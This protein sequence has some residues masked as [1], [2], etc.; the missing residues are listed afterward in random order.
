ME[1]NPKLRTL[2]E[3]LLKDNYELPGYDVFEKD[4]KDPS[5]SKAFYD[6]LLKDNYELP[7]YD[8]FV[9]DLGL[10]KKDA[11]DYG[12][13]SKD[14]FSE[15][16]GTISSPEV[17]RKPKEEETAEPES[18]TPKEFK[19]PDL[20]LQSPEMK[21]YEEPSLTQIIGQTLSNDRI[22]L[23]AEE[24][25][26]EAKARISEIE[27]QLAAL[28][29]DNLEMMP[30]INFSGGLI[31]PTRPVSDEKARLLK[32]K[33]DLRMATE[34]PDKLTYILGKGYNQSLFGIADA[35]MNEKRRASEE[36]LSRYDAGT[37]TDA[38]ATA[39][40]FLIDAPF[41]GMAGKIGGSIGKAAAKPIVDRAVK[42]GVEKLILAGMEE[43]IAKKIALKATTRLSQSIIGMSSSGTALGSY[44]AVNSALSDWSAPDAT[45]D[46]IKWKNAFKRGAKDYVLGLGV[47]GL[48]LG[49][50][51]IAEKARAIK[52]VA[53]RVGTQVGIATGGLT[54]ES[55][56]FTYGGALLDG[57]APNDVTGKEFLETVALLSILK[58][59]HIAQKPGESLKNMYRSAKYDPKKPG[60]GEFQVDLDPIEI[61]SL[62]MSEND[63]NNIMTTLAKDD[64]KLAEVMKDENVPALVKQKVLWGSRGV[65]INGTNLYVDKV[66]PKGETIDLV[67]KEGV[68]VDRRKFSSKEEADQKTL[69]IGLQLE[70]NKMQ[71]R[72]AMPDVDRVKVISDLKNKGTDI[73]KLLTALDKPV[74]ERT[75]EESKMVGDYYSLIPKEDAKAQEKEKKEDAFTVESLNERA[76][77]FGLTDRNMGEDII[78][79][80]LNAK[81]VGL[82]KEV[83]AIPK[84][85]WDQLRMDAFQMY[86]KQPR[87]DASKESGKKEKGAEK[88][89][90]E[91]KQ[92]ESKEDISSESELTLGNRTETSKSEKKILKIESDKV[93]TVP[94]MKGADEVGKATIEDSDAGWRIKWI[95][96]EGTRINK[97]ARGA[98]REAMTMLNKE[99]M[100]EGKVLISDV[101]GKNSTDMQ[102]AWE[103]LVDAGEAV[104]L[105]DKSWAFKKPEKE[106]ITVV[107]KNRELS[108]NE[109]ID[110]V[111]KYNALTPTQK[112]KN[113]LQANTIR[114]NAKRLGYELKESG[115]EIKIGIVKDGKFLSLRRDPVKVDK[116]KIEGQ[117]LLSEHEPKFQEYVNDVLDTNPDLFGVMI[118]GLSNE[119]RAQAFR[120]I[121]AGK[122]TTASAVALGELERMYKTHGG[123]DVW[124]AEGQKAVGISRD[125]IRAE[126]EDMKR[127]KRDEIFNVYDLNES[128]EKGLITKS[129]YDEI[130]EFNR[131]ADEQDRIAEEDFYR[132]ETGDNQGSKE[133]GTETEVKA[134]AVKL[135]EDWRNELSKNGASKKSEALR[136]KL[137]DFNKANFEVGINHIEGIDYSS[138]K[139]YEYGEIDYSKISGWADQSPFF[140]VSTGGKFIPNELGKKIG[141]R[142]SVGGGSAFLNFKY[143]PENAKLVADALNKNGYKTNVKPDQP[144]LTSGKTEKDKLPGSTET[145]QKPVATESKEQPKYTPEQ[146]P[147]VDA[148]NKEYDPKIATLERELERMDEEARNK[149]I[150]DAT[151]KINQRNTL[152]GDANAKET[153]LIKPED[154]GFV[155]SDKPVK[156]A[157][158]QFDERKVELTK[159]ID[160][161]RKEQKSKIGEVLKQKSIEFEEPVKPSIEDIKNTPQ[162]KL[163]AG[164]G[165]QIAEIQSRGAKVDNYQRQLE[166]YE[167]NPSEKGKQKILQL[168]KELGYAELGNSYFDMNKEVPAG[169][170]KISITKEGIKYGDK[171]YTDIEQV[172]DAYDAREITF[173]EQKPL[174]EEV[175]KFEDG[176][177]SE[178][179]KTSETIGPRLDKT[180][181]EAEQRM[182]DDFGKKGNDGKLSVRFIPTLPIMTANTALYEQLVKVRDSGFDWIAKTMQEGMKSQNDALRW[183]TKVA[184]NWA[185][186]IGRTQ[187]DIHGKG[188]LPG[189][190]EFQG[191]VKAFAKYEATELREKWL[192]LVNHDPEAWKRV[193]STLDPEMAETPLK[194][195]D[196]TL[197]EK[198]LYW[199]MKEW[200]TW[201]WATNE[202][203]GITPH[204]SYLKFKGDFDATGYSDYIARMY[205]KFEDGDFVAPEIQEFI[206]RGNSAVTSRMVTDYLNARKEVYGFIEH[207]GKQYA[208]TAELKQGFDAGEMSKDEYD[209]YKKTLS[210]SEW[211][212]EHIITDPTYLT[213]K[214]VMQTIQNVAVKK[215]QQLIMQEHPDFVLSVKA[216]DPIPKGY[217][218]IGSSRSWGLFRN[219]AVIDHIVEDFVGFKYSNAIAN[220]AYDFLKLWDRTK[221][222]QFYK[223]YR[224]V[225]NPMVQ[226]G[227]MTGNVFFASINGINPAKF[228]SKAPEAWQLYHTNPPVFKSLLKSGT[229]GDVGITGEMKPLDPLAIKSKN[230]LTKA[231]EFA[232][233]AYVGA[234]NLAKISAYLVFKEQG[235]SHEKAIRR[236]Y[237]A[238]Q[239]YTTVG[240][241]WDLTSKI[242][243]FGPTFIKFQADLQ[244]ILINNLTTTPLTTIGTLMLIKLAGNL[245]SALSGESEEEQEYRENRKGVPSIPIADIP[246][247]FKVGK[248]ELN[249]ARYLSPLYSY[250]REDSEADLISLS[251]YLPLQLQKV[252]KPQLGETGIGVA[253][254]DAS[255]GWLASLVYDRDFRSM[256]IANPDASRYSNPNISNMER[257]GNR[258]HY[259]ARNQIPFY[260]GAEDMYNGITGNLDYYGRKRDWKQSILN[261]IIKIQEF[262][263]PELKLYMERD[264][265]YLTNRFAAFSERMG[266]ANARYTKAVNEAADLKL[267]DKAISRIAEAHDKRRSI[268][269]EN[270]T[271][272][273]VEIMQELEKKVKAYKRLNPDSP[274]VE[275]IVKNIQSGENRRFNVKDDIDLQKKYKEEYTLLKSNGLLKRPEVPT[276]F[277][278]K[279]LSEEERKDYTSTYWSEYVKQ[280]DLMIGLTP[281]E[282]DEEKKL[283]VSREQSDT[284][285]KQ[286]ETS[287]LEAKAN[288]AAEMARNI[289]KMQLRSKAK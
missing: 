69:E 49:S 107:N 237:D 252:E 218:M 268:S 286:K 152:F 139:P 217:T 189:K 147:K 176:L 102:R 41:F 160:N 121:R 76:Q 119:Q 182:L 205:D 185:G 86:R 200:N 4:L 186:G 81:E 238:F 231:D 145:V 30:A 214:R 106:G 226:L 1:E 78:T 285:P 91:V 79:R 6:D 153:D 64:V 57:R 19:M 191:T 132:D 13:P 125:E 265:D 163:I 284:S 38:T 138:K 278:G 162:G 142:F 275:E 209:G 143:T 206:N 63:Y 283:I 126:V 262:D 254:G 94:I 128:L 11:S 150:A 17:S 165:G 161:L 203:E 100:K 58:V 259:I 31:L 257:W 73:N 123:I 281:E 140:D 136:Q 263:K 105:P 32:E 52:N 137:T 196:L 37:L 14:V 215:Y 67:N 59:S 250:R 277:E 39:L 149:V 40:G 77:K 270:S 20:S 251:K 111:N 282:F 247:S 65:A 22:A 135:E 266:D 97:E 47:G 21:G 95:D 179:R 34:D 288:S 223:K 241:T 124:N 122:K 12:L 99:A 101:E 151:A 168:E 96:V 159:Q 207:N 25:K 239:N 108:K 169:E 199:Q 267:S 273:Q 133:K 112:K 170:R 157:L 5:R 45:F 93:F 244:R 127:R 222:N 26:A 141:I 148:I 164:V 75:P 253:M 158:K 167:K 248:S 166:A 216:G 48:G 46:D 187:A 201:L 276:Y 178:A 53:G 80:I 184:T 134:E 233:K 242:P 74:A 280:L 87:M 213:A 9:S 228:L 197:A 194:Y 225:Y 174:M 116:A 61:E 120:D 224:T 36:Y 50:A 115:D 113:S 289:A 232:T 131:R 130:T 193:W 246:L 287:L 220:T 24:Y 42:K 245:A 261:N 55:A 146:Q 51:A 2:H 202:A 89:Q 33:D 256:S 103:K 183:L 114:V 23:H 144:N 227:N 188:G 271:K 175:R 66:V 29:K 243:G 88:P 3:S 129:E 240:K 85:E 10:K 264:I 234:D 155:V 204:E 71:M 230:F 70:D 249:V 195:G 236:V 219:K 173:E 62:K 35:I 181:R 190:L 212:K 92:P 258:L 84:E 118:G 279:V 56:L 180:A 154:Q 255:W 72:S 269:I 82:S 60:Q 109:V 272:K 16:F 260:K 221:V 210:S 156:E 229:L 211:R 98:G 90:E 15:M 68:I 192:Q 43:N 117:K 208:N 177:T 110:E 54:T 44:G 274:F 8:I 7:S 104:Q 83:E 198:N 172:Q 27:K 235:M 18:I 28:P 171:T